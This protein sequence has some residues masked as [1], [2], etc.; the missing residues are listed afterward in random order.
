MKRAMKLA[1]SFLVFSFFIY[2]ETGEQA[3]AAGPKSS[4][5]IACHDLKSVLPEDHNPVIGKDITGCLTCHPPGKPAKAGPNP[6]SARIHRAH[7]GSKAKVDC[8]VCH[9]WIA[10]KSFSLVKQK[11][12]WGAPSWKAMDLIRKIASSWSDSSLLDSLHA[13]RHVTCMGCHGEKLPAKDD[14]VENDRCLACHGTYDK[15]A[16][17]TASPQFPKRNPHKAHVIGLAC[18]KCHHVHSE[19]KVYCLE[20]HP[21]FDMKISG[22]R[23]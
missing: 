4:S 22:G 1:I 20:C 12:S 7:I 21:T 14:T 11:I 9:T 3:L 8:L 10:G 6:F 16:E 15:L 19:S 5:C 17:K 2:G 13:R 18:T 23:K